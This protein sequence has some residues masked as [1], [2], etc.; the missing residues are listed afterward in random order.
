[1]VLFKILFL[2]IFSL[3]L[4][5]AEMVWDSEQKSFI[6]AQEYVKAVR[7]YVQMKYPEKAQACEACEAYELERQRQ[8]RNNTVSLYGLMWQDNADA[9]TVQKNW[10]GAVEYCQNL[11]LFGFNDWRLPTRDELLSI[12]DKNKSPTIK[13]EFQNVTS[14]YYWSS[15]TIA[16][17]SDRAW[18]VYFGGGDDGWGGK[19]LSLYVRCVRSGQ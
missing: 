11:T 16:S 18:R 12:V 4:H 7:E 15:T 1:M 8:I 17:D 19:T 2:M 13:K 6:G 9:K 3:F 5:S 10:N 14:S